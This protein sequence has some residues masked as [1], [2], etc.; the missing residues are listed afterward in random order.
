MTRRDHAVRSGLAALTSILLTVALTADV[1]AVTWGSD[2]PLAKSGTDWAYP[3][4][5]AV[6][7]STTAHVVYEQAVLGTFGA[8]YR[9]TTDSGSTWSVPILL[10]RPGAGEAGLPVIEANG[11]SL[12][13]AW[14]ESDNILSGVDTIVVSRRSVDGGLTWEPPVQLSPSRESAGYPR[15]A[16][17]GNTVTLAWTNGYNGS[18]YVRRS[19]DGGS[20]WTSR[21]KIATTT[22]KPFGGSVYEAFPSPAIGT[23]VQYLAY[24]SASKTLKVRRSTD[25][26]VHWS[27]ASTLATNA[28]KWAPTV[29]ATGSTA[30]VG[31]ATRSSTDTWTTRRRTTNKGSSWGSAK[32]L[33]SSSSYPSF[34]PV[35]SYRG[36]RWRVIFERC[37]SN[38]CASSAVYYKSSSDGSTW[39]SAVKVS[40]KKRAYAAPGDI[41]IATKTLVV[42]DDYNSSGNDPYVRVGS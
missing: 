34:E 25:G 27:S 13:A 29:A 11:S 41:D 40:V 36:G 15:L 14:L 35:M 3:G 7:S 6:S 12:I 33:S 28:S 26:G 42:Y 38:S 1:V 18:I 20:A 5:L 10:S 23:G 21:Q 22:S 2:T 32:E 17:A 8:Y 19:T 31:Y 16:R 4:S 39:S 30:V 37:L 24:V 9:R